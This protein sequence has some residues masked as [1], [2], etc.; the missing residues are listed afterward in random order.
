MESSGAI[1]RG[2]HDRL[3]VVDGLRL[4]SALMVVL[5]HLLNGVGV[6]DRA[7]AASTHQLFPGL[8][9]VA[10]YGWLGVEMFFLISG[11]VICMSSWGRTVGEF[12]VARVVRLYPAYWFAV[13]VTTGVLALFPVFATHRDWTHVLVNMTMLQSLMGVPDVEQAY[14]T[15][16]VELLFYVLFALVV[17]A[18]G[19]T[20][21]RVVAFCALWTLGTLFAPLVNNTAVF[22][23][24]GRDYAQY[25]IAGIAFYLMYRFGANAM[26]WAIVGCSWII[27]VSR[28]WREIDT[29]T[30]SRFL[31]A[32]ACVTVF[33][34]I[35]ALVANGMTDRI[36]W[37]WL[38]T[39]GALTY[40]L[41]L[42]HEQI[43]L[44]VITAARPYLP[45]WVL[46]GATV[47][48]L[49]LLAYLV[50]RL[51]ERPAAKRLRR[52]LL[53]SLDSVRAADAP[54]AVP[55]AR[56]PAPRAP[57]DEPGD[58]GVIDHRLPRP[59]AAHL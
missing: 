16:P 11:F 43:G 19:V 45:A 28:L 14:W 52:A 1:R 25:F 46:L 37:R 2:G 22:I 42:L 31:P 51:V 18:R 9:E 27:A 8:A 57:A 17:M 32:A 58:D 59:S 54:P 55:A 24:L 3:V 34:V 53:R 26:L 30:T 56:T 10:A 13:V 38:T 44:T 23:F 36:R 49:L 35:M 41:Y 12:A 7:W 20:Y 39:A 5:Y 40:P 15:L 50:H 47:V 33:F 29:Y 48:G 4:I 21:R 6:R